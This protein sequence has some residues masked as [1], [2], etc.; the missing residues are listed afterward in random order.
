MSPAT[1]TYK[2]E[3]YVVMFCGSRNFY[4][5]QHIDDKIMQLK[6]MHGDS[7]VIWTGGAPGADTL[8]EESARDNRV[9]V[10]P[11]KRPDYAKYENKKVAPIMRNHEMV[12][13]PRVRQVIAFWDGESEG[14]HSVIKKCIQQKKNLEIIFGE[15]GE[16][17]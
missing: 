5:R 7:L 13:D 14:T 3:D 9:R 4:L 1:V 10:L 11:S 17:K 12:E 16:W 15:G 2:R 8:A 6:R